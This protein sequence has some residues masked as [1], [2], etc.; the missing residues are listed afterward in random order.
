MSTRRRGRPPGLG[1]PVPS[2]EWAARAACA[3]HPDPGLWFA[4]ADDPRTGKALAICAACPVKAA[5]LGYALSVP[6]L[7]GTWGGTTRTQRTRL[8]NQARQHHAA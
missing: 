5:C 3:G 8:R 1:R 6:G 4:R 2:W 7:H